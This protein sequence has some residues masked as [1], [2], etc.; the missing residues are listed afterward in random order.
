MVTID[1]RRRPGGQNTADRSLS[2]NRRLSC[3]LVSHG[4]TVAEGPLGGGGRRTE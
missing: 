3:E 2:A 4:V 1:T